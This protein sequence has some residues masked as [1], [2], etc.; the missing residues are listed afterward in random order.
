M[1]ISSSQFH[2]RPGV[3]DYNQ[4]KTFSCGNLCM[5]LAFETLRDFDIIARRHRV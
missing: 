5:K 2:R 1:E 3:Q 4:G